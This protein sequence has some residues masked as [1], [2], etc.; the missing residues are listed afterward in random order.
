CV[1]GVGGFA[2]NLDNLNP[3]ATPVPI[4]STTTGNSMTDYQACKAGVP[5]MASS[6]T[7]G[8]P[9]GACW[10]WGRSGQNR[11]NG[12]MT[13]NGFSCD[14]ANDNSDSDSDAVTAGSRHPGVV[15]CAMLDGSTR[16]IKSTVN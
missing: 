4:S 13:P 2:N 10:W 9:H 7:G 5:L 3:S 14:F 15:N 12:V 8:F 1:I 6:N 11:F 16:A